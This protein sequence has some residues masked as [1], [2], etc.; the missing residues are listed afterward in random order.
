[1]LNRLFIFGA[2]LF[3]SLAS[4]LAIGGFEAPPPAAA[5]H[6]TKFSALK[7]TKLENGLRIIVAERPGLPLLAAQ[8]V[9]LHGAEVDPDNLAGVASMTAE[10]LTK[11]TDKMSAPEIANAIESIGGSLDSEAHWDSSNASV[12]VRSDKAEEALGILAD[13]ILHPSFKQ[14]EIERVRTKTLDGLRV[15]LEQPGTLARFVTARVVFGSGAYGHAANGTPESVQAI[16]RDDILKLYRSYYAP[17]KAVLAL[18]GDITLEQAKTY[19][20]RFFGSWKVAESTGGNF[21]ET[22]PSNAEPRSLVID[23]PLAGQ[24]SVTVAKRGIKR[25]SPQYYSALVAN[26]ALGTGFISR[27]NREIRIKRGLSY[28]AGSSIDARREVG[29]FVAS[30]QT[31]NESAPEV[32]RLLQ[33]ELHRLITDPVA[34]EELKSRQAVLTGGFARNLETNGGYVLQISKMVADDLPLDTLNKFIPSINAITPEKVAEFT[35]QFFASPPDLII[36]GKAGEFIEALKKESKNV[37]VI[38]QSD[39]DLAKSELKKAK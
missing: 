1:M 29:P 16:Q 23:M 13:V 12:V 37:E 10:L 14:E 22:P 17:E 34:G 20:E 19:G 6:E 11:G 15:A 27:L 21:K 25:N 5:P 35:A 38:A 28:G 4:T 24:A 18:A 31:K 33:T 30:A 36:V 2:F 3:G 39:L 26:A 8:I 9:I 32:A 7:E